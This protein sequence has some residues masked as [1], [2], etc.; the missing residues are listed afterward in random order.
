MTRDDDNF[1]SRW[2]RRKIEARKDDKQGEVPKT[3]NAPPQPVIP[4][5]AG[6]QPTLAAGRSA[7]TAGVVP[8]SSGTPLPPIDSLTLDSDFTPFLQPGV[9]PALKREALRKLVRDPRFNVM[10][11]L[12]VYIDDYS[13]PDPLPEGWLEKLNQLKNLGHSLEPKEGGA[14]EAAPDNEATL[15]KRIEEQPLRSDSAPAQ[16]PVPE[17][18]S[19]DSE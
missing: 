13:K 16:T 11:G 19:R 6:I 17:P 1:L 8:E 2:S 5:K 10:D 3:A 14:E 15:Q 7:S 12:D 18:R 9:D 4:A